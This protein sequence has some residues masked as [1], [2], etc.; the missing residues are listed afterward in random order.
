MRY[1]YRCV[2]HGVIEIFHKMLE[3]RSGRTC[4][5]CNM[6]VSPIISGGSQ[7]IL[8]GRP[9]WAYNDI[10][11]SAAASER[12]KLVNENTKVTDKRDG[13]KYKGQSRKV[14]NSMGNFNAQ[15]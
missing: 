9:P 10:I 14:D 8:K 5:I 4:P 6:K 2:E 12:S 15:W 3:S 13:S 1:E 11:K 7:I